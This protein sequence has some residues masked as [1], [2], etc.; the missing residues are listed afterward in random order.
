MPDFGSQKMVDTGASPKEHLC[1]LAPRGSPKRVHHWT[2]HSLRF[3]LAVQG[4][5]IL[6][7]VRE[8]RSCM[9]HGGAKIKELITGAET[10]PLGIKTNR[11]HC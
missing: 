7:L 1:Y 9:P 11:V 5:W 6:S 4:T 3:K 8:L 2:I 10:S